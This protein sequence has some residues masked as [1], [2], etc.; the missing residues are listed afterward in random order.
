MSQSLETRA[1]T[2]EAQFPGFGLELEPEADLSTI[3]KLCRGCWLL[4]LVLLVRFVGREAE[5]FTQ[6]D[7]SVY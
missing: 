3:H 4:L 2:S 1:S 5:Y 6:G 7:S